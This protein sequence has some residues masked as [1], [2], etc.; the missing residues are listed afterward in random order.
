MIRFSLSFRAWSLAAALL[1]SG[2]AAQMAYKD[3][4]ELV[5]QGHMAEGLAKLE[6]ASRLDPGV[7]QYRMAW[8]QTRDRWLLAQLERAQTLYGKGQLEGA[9]QAYRQVLSIQG[10]NDRALAG[11]RAIDQQRRGD[12]WLK[13]I[14]RAHV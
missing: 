4:Q 9:E 8:I 3:G 5:S 1:L 14:G 6:E 13:E 7:A 11:L 2:C 12:I 10:A